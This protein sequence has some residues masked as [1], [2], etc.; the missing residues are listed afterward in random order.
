[1]NNINSSP[2]YETSDK[3]HVGSIS[4]K[5][6]GE[7]AHGEVPSADYGSAVARQSGAMNHAAIGCKHYA[8]SHV[9]Q[10]LI[11]LNSTSFRHGLTDTE[12]LFPI[13]SVVTDHGCRAISDKR[14]VADYFG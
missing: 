8:R 12:E 7:N 2:W 4:D 14:A 1:V 6:P 5:P 10:R 3:R 11:W 13:D 9:S